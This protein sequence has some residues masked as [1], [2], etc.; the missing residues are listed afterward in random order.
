MNISAADLSKK[1]IDPL[2]L[3]QFCFQ[4]L[5]FL[6]DFISSKFKY[7]TECTQYAVEAFFC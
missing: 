1:M 6:S 3:E 4:N 2:D 5:R 7:C